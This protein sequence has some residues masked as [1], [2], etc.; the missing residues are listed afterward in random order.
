MDELSALR[1]SFPF[2]AVIGQ[3]DFKLALLAC[4]VDPAIGGVLATGDR[5]TAKSTLA[6]SFA[7][8]LPR[9]VDDVRAPF[10]ELPLGA[11]IDRL[12]G[13]VD[14]ARLLAGEGAEMMPGL[15][16]AANGG[17][18]Y[19]D[20]VNLLGDH[21]VDLL[22]DAA[23]FG[24]VQVERDGISASHDAR[25]V[26]VGTMNPEEGELRPQLLDRFGLSVS[27]E[28]PPTAAE[29]T[30][31]VKRRLA[32]ERDP[33]TFAK[34]YAATQSAL[35][36]IVANARAALDA[37]EL[38]TELLGLISSLCL[39]LDVEGMR[40]DVVTARTAVS[41][42][43][44]D[45]R[46]RVDERDI[47]TAARLALAHRGRAAN[48]ETS[49][50]TRATIEAALLAVGDVDD[51]DV[52]ETA[53]T[54]ERLA[55]QMIK[56]RP[57]RSRTTAIERSFDDD[58]T[59]TAASRSLTEAPDR[60]PI[61]L[62]VSTTEVDRAAAATNDAASDAASAADVASPS[63]E[64]IAAP[65]VGGARGRGVRASGGEHPV[66]DSVPAPRTA[67]A[68]ADLDPVASARAAVTRR[69]V[70]GGPEAI[71]LDDLRER[72]RAGRE[73]NLVLC[74]VDASSSVLENGRAK[75][76]RMLLTSLVADVR[77]KR[78]R[79][80]LVVFRGRE[81][82]LAA[83]PSRNHAAVLGA[84]ESIEPGGTTPLA[85][86]I[87]VAHQTALRE[88]RRNPDLRPVVALITDGYA[89]ISR[90]GDAL[91]EARAAA[92][93]LQRDK[94]MLVVIGESGSG[95]PSFARHT[96][97]HF[98]PFDPPGAGRRAA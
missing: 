95:A 18:L 71:T 32:F 1:V 54:A 94:I 31:I 67:A 60:R 11:T 63:L 36:E 5:G 85:E 28:S 16:A 12:T 23:A 78:D 10:I 52:H 9:D 4:A 69:L 33:A 19:A 43:A 50:V 58:A 87:R 97:A 74:V 77:R 90:G 68:G 70:G 25:F 83:P 30:A 64:R 89:N 46:E 81:A 65:R 2:A 3:D 40:G 13:S 47:A 14:T 41:L 24:R 88:L 42:A 82:R 55:P 21:L 29:R 7:E 79:V 26:L 92:R 73:A 98:H 96:R 59:R 84:L 86:G 39:R 91:G 62:E 61:D 17:V 51:A 80:G 57:S 35:G 8:L 45:A 44:L 75:E 56:P 27:I 66:V 53:A 93:A 48:G 72:V 34:G 6:R 37:V 38:P 76:L 15:L 20:E 49:R 22:L